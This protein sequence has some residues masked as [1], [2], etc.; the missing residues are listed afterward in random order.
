MRVMICL[1]MLFGCAEGITEKSTQW[2]KEG[3]PICTGA[4]AAPV[5]EAVAKGAGEAALGAGAGEAA[6]G[7][8]AG[9]LAGGLAGGLAA[10]ETTAAFLSG[11]PEA[12]AGTQLPVG[13]ALLDIT[14]PGAV[15]TAAAAGAALGPGSGTPSI[16]PG[17]AEAGAGAVPGGGAAPGVPEAPVTPAPKPAPI[18]PQT[19]IGTPAPGPTPVSSATSPTVSGATVGGGSGPGIPG[20]GTPGVPAPVTDLSVPA[21]AA[22]KT[23]LAGTTSIADKAIKAVTSN[24]LTAGALGM[25][26]LAQVNAQKQGKTLAG[27]MKAAAKPASSVADKFLAEGLSGKPSASTAYE[28]DQWVNNQSASIKQR[29]ANMGRDPNNDSAAAKELSDIN[30]K[31][32]AMKDAAAQGLVTQGLNAANIAQGPTTQ[33]ALAAAQQD[34]DLAAS[35]GATLQSLALLQAIQSRTPAV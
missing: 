12:V 28:I 4:E 34:K 10:P 11:V 16:L 14:A 24:P 18:G 29:Y 30:A 22:D 33:A 35:M 1:W 5:A 3:S 13:G 20:G 8:G 19:A 2:W 31:A 6:F 9:E 7:A 25:N 27:Q 23:R 21:S 15:E 17:A 26:A 32:V